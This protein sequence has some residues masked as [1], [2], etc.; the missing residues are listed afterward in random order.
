MKP[1]DRVL[2]SRFWA[3]ATKEI[4]QILHNKQLIFLLLFPP[5]VQLLIFG[6]ALSP[7][8]DHLKLGVVDYANTYESRELVQALTANNIFT[9][10][11]QGTDESALVKQVQQ[12]Q[13]S[14]GLIIPP[15]FNHQLNLGQTAQVQV[16]IDGVDA[17]TAG[18][19]Q[20][21]LGQILTQYSL[22]LL[23]NPPPQPVQTQSVFFYNPGLVSS[24]FLVPGVMG[25]VLTLTSSLISSTTLV[26][27]KD[28]GTLEQLLMTP[29]NG[30]E[31]LA[32]KIVPLFALLMGDVGLAVLIARGVFQVPFRGSL[33]L[34]L[35]L[36]GLYLWVGIGIGLMLATLAQS[37]EQVVLISFFVNLPLIQTSG[38]I[39]PIESMP[40][41]F[42]TLSWFNPLRHFV[43]IIR[44]ILLKGVGLEVLWP[45]VL[46]LAAFATLLMTVSITQFRR[47]LS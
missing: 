29:A 38:A 16:L 20:G 4:N 19:A 14:T 5:T 15:N 27:E 42:Q 32:A 9:L 30:W 46:M 3:L 31:I 24:W 8:V 36:A 6:F 25:V 21:Y 26:K 37:Q 18:I 13:L 34:Y 40:P 33:L 22:S 44:G 17:N 28:T 39:A 41:F 43:A 7:D 12:G 11:Y 35:G 1:L 10:H 47:Q 2:D 23:P 45:H